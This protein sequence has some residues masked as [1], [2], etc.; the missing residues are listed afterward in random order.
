MPGPA[1]PPPDYSSV[2]LE[3]PPAAAVAPPPFSALVDGYAGLGATTTDANAEG[4]ATAG[5]GVRLRLGHYG[6]GGF[7]QMG[8]VRD[9]SSDALGG[10]LS[11]YL[12]YQNFADLEVALGGGVHRFRTNEARFQGNY[13]V[14]IPMATLRIGVSSRSNGVVGARLGA[15]L[16][17]DADLAR[18]DA[19]WR[20]DARIEGAP[21]VTGVRRLGG[22]ATMLMFTVGFDVS[23]NDPRT[24]EDDE[25]SDR[26]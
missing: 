15:A 20:A 7:G 6:L 2:A 1:T 12:P 4:L 13:D 23:P 25:P 8:T 14:S 24:R 21:D 26:P 5:V 22:I 3:P 17:I 10:T 19:P 16:H 11:Y 9:G 18:Q